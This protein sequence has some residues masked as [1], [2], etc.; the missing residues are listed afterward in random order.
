[1]INLKMIKGEKE[2]FPEPLRTLIDMSPDQMEENEFI[3]F[4]IKLRKK[5]REMD[6]Q[7]DAPDL[8]S[9]ILRERSK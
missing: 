5:A 3:N 7:R 2:R 8:S 4:F 6:A 9:S 1:M